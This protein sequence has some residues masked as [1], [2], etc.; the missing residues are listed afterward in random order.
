M[1]A[2]QPNAVTNLTAT[3]VSVHEIDLAWTN[4]NPRFEAGAL[5]ERT[6]P[7][8]DTNFAPVATVAAGARSYVDTTVQPG[9]RYIYRVTALPFSSRAFVPAQPVL[10]SASI[11]GQPP[12][13]RLPYPPAYR[14]GGFAAIGHIVAD[15]S[16]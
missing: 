13:I 2:S 15:G 10:V 8:Q 12:H 16:W 9:S 3:I 4:D 5:I 6:T 7:G 11:S 1:S 14:D